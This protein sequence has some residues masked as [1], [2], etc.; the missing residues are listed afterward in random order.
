VANENDQGTRREQ[1]R[2]KQQ[3][4]PSDAAAKSAE[5]SAGSAQEIRDRNARLR[6]KAAADRQSKRDEARARMAATASGLDAS[7]R[8]DDIF[9]R[10]TH[11]VTLWIRQNFKWLQWAL[12][13]C[14]IG[15]F[16][17]QGWRYYQRQLAAKSTD[18]L[19]EGAL[20]ESGTVGDDEE[21]KST[22]EELR[23]WDMRP[24]FHDEDQ[25]LGAAEKNFKAAIER[26]GKTGAGDHARL[27]LAGIKYDQMAFDE[28]LALYRQVRS[29]KLASEDLEVKGRAIEGIGF[30]LEAKSDQE[31]A[32][33]SFRE[34][35]NLEGS[36]EF[37][38]LG[39]YHQARVLTA[40]GKQ[41][42]AKDLLNKA[43]KRLLD[44]KESMSASY[45]K[46]PIQEALARIDPTAAAS[47]ASSDLSELLRRDPTRFQQM[48]NGLK[49][50]GSGAPPVDEPDEPQ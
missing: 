29:S 37:A 1:R 13:L 4:D 36:L 28:A 42:A 17:V 20:A 50:K 23:R 49:H 27:Q 34:L 10:T 46:K 16:A 40:Q 31:G 24:Q 11:A 39:L 22:P 26:Y 41:D 35:S 38:V 15:M 21:G 5:D 47:G 44:D 19:M 9:V 30:C 45:Y 14:V 33:K 8:L 6:A 12:V 25:R 43:Q 2:A 18:L 3:A 7:E 48:L 32:L